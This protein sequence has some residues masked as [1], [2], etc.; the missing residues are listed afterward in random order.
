[1]RIKPLIKKIRFSAVVYKWAKKRLSTG[2]Y[3]V[4][5]LFSQSVDKAHL[6]KRFPKIG[7]YPN[8][9]IVVSSSLTSFGHVKG[10]AE[11]IVEALMEYITPQGLIVMP[12]YPHTN[13]Y[14]YLESNPVFNTLTSPS[15][16]G[17]IS[18][19]FR[20]KQDV[21]R[22][23][24]PT[25]CLAAWGKDAKELVSGHQFSLT[26]YAE[27]SPYKALLDMNA[28]TVLFGVNLNHAIMIRVIDDLYPNYPLSPYIPG[29]VYTVECI[30]DEGNTYQ[31]V[32]PCHDPA[33]SKERFNMAIYPYI[34]NMGISS[35]IGKSK[36]FVFNSKDL[37]N[38]QIELSKKGIFPFYKL[39]LKNR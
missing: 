37:F 15:Q 34:K 25:H 38:K 22:S 3:K 5:M 10:G 19:V 21:F 27:N 18:E 9:R 16:N 26:P 31:V 1:M 35:K 29:K 12:T 30:D 33:F 2:K 17:K 11:T 4:S 8:D 23:C 20:K 24:H 28:K 39:P 6:M 7:I 14:N 13:M 36:T 32:T